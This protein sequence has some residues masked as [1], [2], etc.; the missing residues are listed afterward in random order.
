M[1]SLLVLAD[2]DAY[3]LSLPLPARPKKVTHVKGDAGPAKFYS[4][5][6]LQKKRQ[7]KEQKEREKE[8]EKERKVKEKEKRKQERERKQ[9]E[10]ET[11]KRAREEKRKQIE[12]RRK[13]KREQ[14]HDESD[15]DT[16]PW[17]V[18]STT[19]DD[20]EQENLKFNVG[21]QR[22]VR[23]SK[24]PKRYSSESHIPSSVLSSDSE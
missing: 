22:R 7:E 21:S 14:Y 3:D 18:V 17:E 12:A 6:E 8:K 24:R 4:K 13:K 15:A 9:Q 20:A 11:R 1:N 16:E 5:E 10:K 23:N 2:Q 19:D